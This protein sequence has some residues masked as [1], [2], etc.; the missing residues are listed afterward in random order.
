M[1]DPDDAERQRV[2]ELLRAGANQQLDDAQHEEL[3]LYRNDRPELVRDCVQQI[4]AGQSHARNSPWLARIDADR[5]L[6]Q[7]QRSRG[8]VRFRV[9]SGISLAAALIAFAF[10]PPLAFLFFPLLLLVYAGGEIYW[11]LKN[12]KRDPY[13][14]IQQ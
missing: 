8:I 7:R 3:Q 14:D 13:R 11:A 6:A 10:W 5:T 9:M 1:V 12:A 4:L 2:L